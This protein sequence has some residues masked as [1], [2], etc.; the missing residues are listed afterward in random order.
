MF[1]DY[2]PILNGEGFSLEL[3]DQVYTSCVRSC[4]LCDCEMWPIKVG[5]EVQ[6]KRSKMSMSRWTFKFIVQEKSKT[7]LTQGSG[8]CWDWNQ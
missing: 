5:D 1:C 8:N 4:L 7:Q 6:L 2:L 3:K